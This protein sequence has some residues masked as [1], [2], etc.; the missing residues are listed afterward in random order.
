VGFDFTPSVD[1]GQVSVNVELA[2]GASLEATD[3][4]MAQVEAVAEQIPEVDRER[5]LASIGEIIG[6]FGSLPDRG[7]QI[8]Q[9]T[10]MLT[11]KQGFVERLLHPAGQAGRR[12][13]SDEQVAT[14]LRTRLKGLEAQAKINVSAVRGLTA[15]LA[16]IQI[17]LY[18]NDAAELERVAGQIEAR[19]A[20]VPG[21]Q[22][23]DSSLRRGKPEIQVSFNRSRAE[24]LFATPAELA[25]ALR[26]AVAGNTDFRLRQ[27]DISYP[28]RVMLSRTGADA[29]RLSPEAL[30]DVVV[31]YRGSSPVYVGDIA[32][33]RM[34]AGPTKI[35]R[36]QRTR[37]VILSAHVQEGV[38]L[39]SARKAVDAALQDLQLGTVERRWEGDVDDM[40]ESAGLMTGA[41]LL[42]IALS[43]MLMAGVFNSL[44][45]PLTIM[46]SVPMALVGG[47][48]GLIYTGTTM[49]IV[50]M[51]GI[52]M[53]IGLVSKN[54]ILLVDYTN[55]LRQRGLR[56]DA[57]IEAAGPVRLRPILMTTTSTVLAMT[58][59]ALQ[60]GRASEMRSPMAIVVIGGLLLSTLLTLLVVPVMY[61]YFDDLAAWIMR[62]WRRLSGGTAPALN[63][64][65]D[66]AGTPVRHFERLDKD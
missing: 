29:L 51:I 57:A 19:M 58:P 21:L 33:V 39:G 26:T 17:G 30:R 25:G 54:A 6:G 59:V 35:L 52:V 45:H 1:R 46:V 55:T 65:L 37:R 7:S 11:E 60:I 15:A 23:V 50:S 31:T 13:R 22:N 12:R 38:S 41:I 63:S 32:D 56:R 43:Y 18:G 14:E 28:V 61:S 53:L 34:G 3:A 16:P 62:S 48:L 36:S 49:N 44:I 8:G 42:A 40:E 20:K 4:V 5:M 64:V 10:L 27:Q 66:E 47:L 2:P 9:L 24:E